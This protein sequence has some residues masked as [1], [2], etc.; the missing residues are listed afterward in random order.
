MVTTTNDR[1]LK[2]HAPL[3]KS[4]V[5]LVLVPVTVTDSRN[6]LVHGLDK[7][8]FRVYENNQL[9]TVQ[10]LSRED[11]PISVGILLDTSESMTTKVESARHAVMEFI[12]TSN[13]A[14]EFFLI[15]F[16]DRPIETVEFTSAADLIQDRL[17]SWTPKG[18]TALLDALYLGI[19]KMHG[20]K[21]S[22]RALLVISDGGDNHSRYSEH[23][24]RGVIKEADVMI[25]AIGI[26][27]HYFATTEELMGPVLLDNVAELTGGYSFTIDN[28]DDLT[29]AAN[30]IGH[31][32]RN[33]Y[34]ISYRPTKT[35]HDGKWHKTKVMV[36]LPRGFPRPLV[37]AKRGYYAP[38]D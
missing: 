19:A 14:D 1:S 33:L 13:P 36:S 25:Y 20:A 35:R 32:L 9:Q 4:G 21:Y 34:V 29:M 16:S 10:T 8:N 11:A 5:D 37:H 30:N 3:F 31:A 22:R 38:A 23:E 24:L 2:A 18:Q 6:R 28:P 7:D 26:Y 27:D 15:T 17:V 12:K